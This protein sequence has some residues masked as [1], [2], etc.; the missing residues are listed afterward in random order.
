MTYLFIS[1]LSLPYLFTLIAGFVVF[2]VI[3]LVAAPLLGAVNAVD[4][5]NF[6]TMSSGLGVVSKV[7][8]LPLL[9]M[10][11]LC[12]KKTKENTLPDDK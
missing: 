5:E 6:R 2:L 3:Y 10:R 11:K 12:R 7:F 1:V 8:S 9:F 4:I